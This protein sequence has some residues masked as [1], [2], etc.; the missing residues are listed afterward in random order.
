MAGKYAVIVCAVILFVLAAGCAAS[1]DPLV[2]KWKQDT[3][4]II[5]T[6]DLKEGGTGTL[7]MDMSAV[8][9]GTPNEV[10]SLT[11]KKIN[12]TCIQMRS[13]KDTSSYPG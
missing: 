10:V 1:T 5:I 4:G 9:P 2:G 7:T 8:F 6:M 13:A 12:D 11:W 3:A